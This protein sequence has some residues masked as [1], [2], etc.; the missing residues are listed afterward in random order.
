[1]GDEDPLGRNDMNITGVVRKNHGFADGD[2]NYYVLCGTA[3]G[4]GCFKF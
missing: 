3:T 1:M 4:G 2:R